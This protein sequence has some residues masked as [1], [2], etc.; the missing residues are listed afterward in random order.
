MTYEELKVQLDIGD[1]HEVLKSAGAGVSYG[2][3]RIVVCDN[4][5][6]HLFGENGEELDIKQLDA[7]GHCAFSGCSSLTSIKIPNSVK[8]IGYSAFYE[9]T[10]LTSIKVPESVWYIGDWVFYKCKSLESIIIPASVKNIGYNVFAFCRSLKSIVFKGK[11]MEQ[12][13]AMR[14]YPWGI[15]SRLI[16]A[17]A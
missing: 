1:P 3:T 11:T 5:D 14:Y 17:C 4:G 15:A 9:C 13:K 16:T 8:R 7:I 6:C 10:S 12:V 2:N